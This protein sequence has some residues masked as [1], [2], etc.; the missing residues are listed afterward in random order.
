MLLPLL[1]ASFSYKTE[2]VS[3]YYIYPIQQWDI[4]HSW[5]TRTH[6]E[7]T[8]AFWWTKQETWTN[9]NNERMSKRT[10]V[11][12]NER[13]N[14]NRNNNNGSSGSNKKP[15]MYGFGYILYTICVST[16][17]SQL[18][19]NIEIQKGVKESE[20]RTNQ[21]TSVVVMKR[22]HCMDIHQHSTKWVCLN[23]GSLTL[24]VSSFKSM[25]VIFF[26]SSSWWFWWK[27]RLWISWPVC[28]LDHSMNSNLCL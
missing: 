5:H 6:V 8:F 3:I 2:W 9:K 11:R 19:A 22:T 17:N 25:G 13:M 26:S 4:Q 15:T 20:K 21:Q 18:T 14:N 16:N 27:F 7:T 10:N 12:T 23:I 1:P 24:F 28:K